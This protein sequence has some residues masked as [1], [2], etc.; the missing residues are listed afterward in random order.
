MRPGNNGTGIA[1]KH[2][3][4]CTLLL[5]IVESR[6]GPSFEGG[7]YGGVYGDAAQRGGGGLLLLVVCGCGYALQL[8]W[9]SII[10][11]VAVA[12]TRRMRMRQLQKVRFGIAA[13]LLAIAPRSRLQIIHLRIELQRRIAA[14]I[15]IIIAIQRSAKQ[16][17]G[18]AIFRHGGY[19]RVGIGAFVL[20]VIVEDGNKSIIYAISHWS[21]RLQWGNNVLCFVRHFICAS[22][23]SNFAQLALLDVI[24]LWN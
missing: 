14:V 19:I 5:G 1:H 24:F 9:T 15:A 2:Q 23:T 20:F 7:G 18:A 13:I 16:G 10:V 21:W 8:V 6:H 22:I 11:A 4:S 12:V 3:R 17:L